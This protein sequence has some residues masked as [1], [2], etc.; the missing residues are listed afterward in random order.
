MLYPETKKQLLEFIELSPAF[1]DCHQQKHR[2]MILKY[3]LKC[4]H[5][6]QY[7]YRPPKKLLLFHT[8]RIKPL[9]CLLH[10]EPLSRP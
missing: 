1:V 9:V 2:V 8:G 4:S 5:C 10:N 3:K 6:H 7:C